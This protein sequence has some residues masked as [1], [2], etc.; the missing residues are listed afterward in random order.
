MLRMALRRGLKFLEGAYRRL[1]LEK[2][3]PNG[4]LRF[5]DQ[6]G[7][8]QDVTPSEF[9]TNWLNQKWV[10]DQNSLGEGSD[11][12]FVGTP[13]LLD[14][15]AEEDQREARK[16]EKLLLAVERQ[17]RVGGE[18][19][20]STPTKLGPLIV[21]AANAI[22]HPD[23]PT[24][25]TLWRWWRKYAS[26]RCATKL[27]NRRSP[28]RPTHL[29]LFRGLFDEAVEEVYLSTQKLP[30]KELIARLTAKVSAYNAGVSGRSKPLTNPSKAT[31]Y[32][33]V[34]LLYA[35]LVKAA[36]EG[37]KVAERDLRIVVSGLKVKRV[38]DRYE[39]D[40]TPMD[41]I[42]ICSTT[43][44]ILGRPWLTLAI[45]RFSRLIVGFYISYHAPSASSV[46][47]CVKQAILP[48]ADLLSKY[49]DIRGPWPAKGIPVTIA[50]DNGMDLHANDFEV[51]A[52]ELG[53]EVHYMGAGYPEMK[54]AIERVIGTVNR[55]F[56]H[57]LPGTTFSNTQQRG[58]YPAE[59]LAVL[60]LDTL[61][62]VLLKWI[63][64][65][66]HKTPH[67]GLRGRTPLEVWIAGAAECSVEM[68]A[69]PRQLD[70]VIGHSACRALWKY[71]V[72][73]DN[74]TYNV[75]R[76]GEM[77]REGITSVTL[78]AF[79][80]QVRFIM[81][82]DTR[83]NEFIEVSAVDCDYAKDLTRHTHSLVMAKVRERFKND[84][85]SE[86]RRAV[87]IEIQAIVENSIQAKKT[88]DRKAN[89]AA[90]GI[91]SADLFDS[92]AAKDALNQA[93]D[94]AEASRDADG[95]SDL[96]GDQDLPQFRA[97][98]RR[99]ARA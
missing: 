90:R 29:K 92:A 55:T 51:P 13:P 6:D 31:I 40:H 65:V 44:L 79:D 45:D 30:V 60:D 84:F 23:P 27:V 77:F 12:V 67:R 72:Q 41:I 64:D 82:L 88:S 66:Y 87:M 57:T 53:V 34:G 20:V 10:I 93:V 7:N 52:L 71:G 28:G 56:I 25:S 18:K 2:R 15:F 86:D 46:M 19:M 5:E 48:K 35:P 76:L 26:T 39:L 83:I 14:S 32:R 50:V 49:P 58:D 85:T 11:R 54:A 42:L 9:D 75:Q 22:N 81:V 4:K 96:V 78:R 74:L 73:Y 68:P 69:Y 99:P 21:E 36:R 91:D 89:A 63:V 24:P 97:H 33:W 61:V 16:K 38:L 3:L 47:H 37:K 59:D 80:D 17:F 8:N 70:M 1:A 98:Q 43:K 62:H 95:L 94:G